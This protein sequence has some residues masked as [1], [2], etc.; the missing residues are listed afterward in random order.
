MEKNLQAHIDETPPRPLSSMQW[1]LWGLAAAGK[2]FEG[3]VIFLTGVAIPLIQK[4]LDLPANLKGAVGAA[5]LFGI[6][7]GASLFGQLAD[8]LG[9]K[10]V[11]VLEMALFTCFIGLTAL[12]WNAAILISLLFCVGVTL[13]ADYPTAHIIISEAIPSR[14]RGR[15]ILAAFS[16]QAVGSLGGVLVGILMLDIYPEL[17]A[18]HWMYGVLV[19]PGIIVTV[20]RSRLPESSHWLLSRNR[21]EE[22]HT[23][24]VKLLGRPVRILQQQ[25]ED[26]AQEP[27]RE[28]KDLFSPRYIRATILTSV[29]WFLQ[30][31]STYGIGL[32][33]PSIIGSLF[34]M[35]QPDLILRDLTAA[36]GA[37]A[38][39]LLLVVGFLV[40]IPLVDRV[41]RIPLQIIGFI[42]CAAGLAI[43]SFS[44]AVPEGS[45]LKIPL[46]FGGFMLFNF[47]TNLGPNAITYVL[48]G[49]VFPTQIRGA[50]AGFAA[51]FAKIGAVSTAFFF[52][53]LRKDIGTATLLQWLVLTALAGALVTYLFRIEPNGKSLEQMGYGQPTFR[54][55]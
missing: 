4:D 20:M 47:M 37:G 7:I 39:D 9:R 14:F 52:P 25:P 21:A 11:F 17:N 50:G 10:F 48:A 18:W 30:D 35:D 55:R 19:I 16:F 53:I 5:L 54:A 8:R 34:S 29:P 2:F 41:G 42:G 36:E 33:T 27:K 26:M 32:F 51:A 15:M 12:A 31:L 1:S 45:A 22:A 49:E 13:G 44:G 43:A 38:I 46:I 40:S 23:A 28:F 3:M 6:L 24:A